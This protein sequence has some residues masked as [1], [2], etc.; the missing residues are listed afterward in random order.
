MKIENQI[1]KIKKTKKIGFMGH[2]IAGFPTLEDSKTAAFTLIKSGTDFLEIQFPFSDPFADG[3]IIEGACYKSLENGFTIEKGFELVKEIS[4]S[5]DIPIFIMTYGN[6]IFKYGIEKFIKKAKENGTDGFIIPDIPPEQDEGLNSIVKKYG[7][8]N[9]LLVTPSCDAER[10]RYVSNIGSGFLYTVMRRGITGK[11]TDLDK[12]VNDYL[13]L[14]RKNSSLPIAVGFGIQTNEQIKYLEDKAEIAIAGSF[15]VKTISDAYK[16][17]E[18]ISEKLK[19]S[20]KN[21]LS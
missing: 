18:N 12:E 19:I 17:Q 11:K 15:L 7:L 5:T 14:V 2:I 21:L 10:I 9:I 20:I 1:E 13:S 3:P 4:A 6:I 16:N 8:T